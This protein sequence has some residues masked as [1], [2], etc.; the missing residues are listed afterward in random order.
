MKS[1]FKLLIFNYFH[2]TGFDLRA[3]R[4][5]FFALRAFGVGELFSLEHIHDSPANGGRY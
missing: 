3:Y 4:L 5:H 2:L 1:A